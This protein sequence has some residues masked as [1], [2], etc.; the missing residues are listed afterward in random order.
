[1]TRKTY[2][3]N[4]YLK[5]LTGKILEKEEKGNEHHIVMDRTIFIPRL[6]DDFK[7]DQ[8]YINGIEVTDVFTEQERIV[9]VLKE[10]IEE[11]EVCMEID[12]NKRFEY[13]QQHTGEHIIR[14]SLGKLCEAKVS[15]AKIDNEYCY[16]YLNCINLN[17]M[18]I[19]RIEKFAN[20]MIYSNFKIT[21]STRGNMDLKF[22]S[23]DNMDTVPCESIHCS[24][25]GEIGI[26][27]I[28]DFNRD[29]NGEI[30]L[31]F[32]CGSRALKDYS[33]KNDIVNKLTDMLNIKDKDLV[34]EIECM[35][36]TE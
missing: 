36:E 18:D 11:T 13:M 3:E 1:M 2:L 8:G 35:L 29:E 16:I 4:P 14:A 20:Y 10:D 32:V 15:E 34:T 6:S 22:I 25:T 5:N 9:H 33:V 24:N 31:K 26:I 23:I 27:K 28:I 7:I 17:E 12:W 21:S 30:E 19:D